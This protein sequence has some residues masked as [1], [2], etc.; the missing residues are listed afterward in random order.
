MGSRFQYDGSMRCEKQDTPTEDLSSDG[1]KT[2]KWTKKHLLAKFLPF[3]AID[4]GF[5]SNVS[6]HNH[7][8][9]IGKALTDCFDKESPTINVYLLRDAV[10]SSPLT[11][12]TKIYLTILLTLNILGIA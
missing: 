2:E 1:K 5:H 8:S 6:T 12:L 11:S 4:I 9:D 7:A 3:L 10:L